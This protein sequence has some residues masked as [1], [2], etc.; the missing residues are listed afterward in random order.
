MKTIVTIIVKKPD[1][2]K[3]KQCNYLIPT[4]LVGIFMYK[5]SKK[6][7]LKHLDFMIID[8]VFLV[9]SY[10]ISTA[11]RFGWRLDYF[12]RDLLVQQGLILL[13][14]YFVVSQFGSAYKNIIRRDRYQ[15]LRE[16]FLQNIITFSIFVLCLYFTKQAFFFS[17]T[18]T[19]Q[20]AVISVVLIYASRIVWKRILRLHMLDN[21]NMPHMLVIGNTATAAKCI[22][23]MHKRRYNEFF[24]SGVVITNKNMVG[25]YVEGCPVVC[26]FNQ[27]RQYVL[28]EVVDEIFIN[29]N[30][31]KEQ[32]RLVDYFLE[33]GVTVHISLLGNTSDLPNKTVEK[34]GGHIVLTT[35]NNMASPLPLFAKRF[36]DIIAA[37]IG[38]AFTLIL[39]LILGPI[40][41]KID[42]GPIFFSQERIGSNGRRFKLYK[43][44]SM[45]MDAEER[46]KELMSKNE[47]TGHM[48]KMENDPRILPFIGKKMRDWSLDEFPQFFNILIGDMSLVGT[49]PPTVDEFEHYDPHHKMR[50]SFKPGLTGNWQVNG[51]SKITDF[52]E[53]VKLD[54][55]YIK[56]WNL[57]LDIKIVFK[58]IAVVLRKD[59][60]M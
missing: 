13:L 39:I 43:F 58:T 57:L 4:L 21:E 6:T 36:F 32:N 51:R 23:T 2:G 3:I 15:E 10:Y 60:S 54:N 20:T 17:R 29:I 28:S 25:D 47:M 37:F 22:R 52:E 5:K 40:I 8:L 56:N 19:Y 1:C 59:G 30:D 26:E 42:P 11:F 31:Q 50:L 53:I 9:L 14:I 7:W 18:V 38:L 48:F 46:K 27:L 49:R 45:Y 33:M 35:S 12:N 16:V 55:D 44:R 24:I 34:M 41:K